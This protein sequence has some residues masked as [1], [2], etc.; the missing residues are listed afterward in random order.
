MNRLLIAT[1]GSPAA[2]AA[3]QAGVQLAA[4]QE[5]GVVFLHVVDAVDVVAP[6][7]GPI[8]V[9]PVE[10]SNPEDDEILS[11]AA[12]VARAHGVPFELRLVAGFDYETILATAD[13]I[14][15][16]LIVLG[17]NRHG[18]LGTSSSEASPRSCS[19]GRAGPCLSSIP[20]RP[21]RQPYD[22]QRKGAHTMKAL[23]YH[24][25]G[26]RSWDEVP[27]RHRRSHRCSRTDRLLHDLRYR[28]A[29]PQGRRARGEAGD[30]SRPRG[31][32]DRHRRRSGNH[33][34][35]GRP[36]AQ[37]PASARRRC[38]GKEARYGLCTGGG[39]WVF[40]HLI[41][42]LQAEYARIPFADT[43][44]YKVPDELSDEQVLFLADILPTAFECGVL[45]GRVEPGDTVAIVGAGLIGLAAIMTA[46]LFTPGK[47][48][49]RPRRRPPRQGTRVRRR[50]RDQQR[51]RGRP[52]A[53]PG[54]HGWPGR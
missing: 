21:S 16:E 53:H 30:D 7:F 33:P 19:S 15:A 9:N 45:N 37:S 51:P 36:R 38:R 44:V 11:G 12:E 54:A 34:R 47:I 18:T 41:D 24:G 17:S 49:D 35:R 10:E 28:S 52:H 6:A 32:G 26:Q 46:K 3:V 20:P 2:E 23:V 13:E 27:D 29:H 4:E 40:G 50:R 43:S 48:S 42:G 14:D 39:G 1:D 31:S 25:P 5:G 8:I 22:Y